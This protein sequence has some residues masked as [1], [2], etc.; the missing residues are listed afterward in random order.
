MPS[1]L[2]SGR[3][4][5][6]EGPEGSGKSTQATYL[7]RHLE[8]MGVLV[9]RTREPGGSIIG[10]EVRSILLAPDRPPLVPAAEALLIAGDRAQHVADVIR[11]AIAS[12][13]VVLCDRYI[14][15]TFAYQGF[16]AGIDFPTLQAITHFATGGLTPDLTILVDVEAR[17]GISRRRAAFRKGTGEFNRM[18]RREME[19]HQRVREG[20]LAL[21]LRE[22]SR[23]LVID[24]RQSPEAVA[25]QIWTRVSTLLDLSSRGGFPAQANQMPLPL[26][27]GW[28]APGLRAH[29][30]RFARR[31]RAIRLGIRTGD[32]RSSA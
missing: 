15:S 4:I 1:T 21:A 2:G 8:R 9:L 13:A 11:P 23:F 31:V 29:M 32:V 17:V 28:L 12:G 30:H 10:P 22:P 6:F 20:F 3:F 7:Q 24:G 25:E 18:D 14:D 5:T 27:E 16:G 26:G 19:F